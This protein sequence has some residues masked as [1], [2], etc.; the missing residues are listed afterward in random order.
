MRRNSANVAS[1]LLIDQVE[2]HGKMAFGSELGGLGRCAWGALCQNG[3]L[4]AAIHHGKMRG[5]IA[6]IDHNADDTQQLL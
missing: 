6:P 1:G 2:A 5:C 3:V 4:A